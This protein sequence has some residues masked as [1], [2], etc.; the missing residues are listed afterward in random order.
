MLY[1]YLKD[2]FTEITEPAGI[3]QNLSPFALE[4][5]TSDV[6][7]SGDLVTPHQMYFFNASPVYAR[8]IDEEA[9]AKVRVVTTGYGTCCCDNNLCS[10]C[11][12]DSSG[13][14][15]DGDHSDCI[16]RIIIDGR[17]QYVSDNTATLNLSAY[18]KGHETVSRSEVRALFR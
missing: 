4:V 18:L 15:D 6:P 11:C 9:T 13:D 1:L 8:C 17:E 16:K 5:S 14:S 7:G 12:G 2:N 3:I 10:S